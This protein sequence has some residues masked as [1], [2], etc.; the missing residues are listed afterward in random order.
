MAFPG[1]VQTSPRGL[2]ATPI[3]PDPCPTTVPSMPYPRA[4]VSRWSGRISPNNIGWAGDEDGVSEERVASLG[5][6]FSDR[7]RGVDLGVVELPPASV[8]FGLLILL[9]NDA[10]FLACGALEVDF[11]CWV[12]DE[13]ERLDEGVG[14]S[15]LAAEREG[16]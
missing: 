2:G 9:A 10:P 12:A 8:V 3:E 13:P 6:L 4:C 5:A 15:E 1:S 11:G 14:A 16:V 7:R